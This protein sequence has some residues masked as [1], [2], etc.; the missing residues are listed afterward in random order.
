MVLLAIVAC[1]GDPRPEAP[2]KPPPRIDAGPGH[3]QPSPDAA[4]QFVGVTSAAEVVDISPRVAGVIAKVHVNT[5]DPVA[6]GQVVAEMDPMQ[7]KEELRAAQA[8]LG[9]AS[10]ATRQASVDLED[11]RRKLAL[12][13]KAVAGGISAQTQLDEAKLGVKRAEAALERAYSSQ[14][15]EAAR[16]QT[17]KDQLT[18]SGLKAPFAGK[19][20]KR[21]LDAGNRVEA[22]GPIVRIVGLGKMRL[23]FA[24]PP[25]LAKLVPV[26]VRVTATIQTVA[27][28]VSATV[29]QITPAVDPAS[30]MIL[31]EAELNDSQTTLSSGLPAWVAPP[32]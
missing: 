4:L 20:E 26:G 24:V 12:E 11:A 5:G 27:Q 1:S 25:D 10:A 9:A 8:A 22:G 19:V 17:A 2:P 13:T 32:T 6:A 7:L 14:A 21:Y 16:A 18:N 31:V 3:A 30:G 23:R 15:A 29:K 28:P